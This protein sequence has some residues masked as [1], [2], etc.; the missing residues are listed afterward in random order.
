MLVS[1][2]EGLFFLLGRFGV[3]DSA[4][5]QR[6]Y[7]YSGA[8]VKVFQGALLAMLR[9]REDLGMIRRWWVAALSAIRDLKH[10]ITRAKVPVFGL[11]LHYRLTA[12]NETC[13]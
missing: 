11:D 10:L 2:I 3:I 7:A 8:T 4:S 12:W 1:N 5:E 9:N 6:L 13:C